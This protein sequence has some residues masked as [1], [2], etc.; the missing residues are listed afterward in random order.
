MIT[1]QTL[2]LFQLS[3]KCVKVL[4]LTRYGLLYGPRAIARQLC[5][6]VELG[7]QYKQWIIPQSISCSQIELVLCPV[8]V[9]QCT[10]CF[11]Y[12]HNRHCQEAPDTHLRVVRGPQRSYFYVEVNFPWKISPQERSYSC[13]W[14]S[15]FYHL[16]RGVARS[17]TTAQHQQW[18]EATAIAY[19]VSF[20]M[21]NENNGKCTARKGTKYGRL[22]LNRHDSTDRRTESLLKDQESRFKIC[23]M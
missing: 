23:K 5:F 7:I 19:P 10:R 3:D 14:T 22:W 18:S 13:E 9:L 4:G 2:S 21:R 20:S 17:A 6:I 12:S 16:S 1:L 15:A 8:E 11:F